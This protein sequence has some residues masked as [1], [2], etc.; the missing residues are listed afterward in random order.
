[1]FI[2]RQFRSSG[3][4]FCVVSL[5]ST[6]IL[7]EYQGRLIQWHSVTSQKTWILNEKTMETSYL[8]FL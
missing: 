7:K 4:W 5:Q 3:L 6:E 1:M 8:A 2:S